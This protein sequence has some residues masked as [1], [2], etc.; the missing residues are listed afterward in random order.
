M[1][2]ATTDD[3]GN[4]VQPSIMSKIGHGALRAVE[5]IGRV[6]AQTLETTGNIV[7]PGVMANIP[8]SELQRDVQYQAATRNLDS[9]EK[10]RQLAASTE[11]DRAKASLEQEQA[12]QAGLLGNTMGKTET[13]NLVRDK[14]FGG[15]GGTAKVNPKTQQPWTMGEAISASIEEAKSAGAAPEEQPLSK[16]PELFAGYKSRIDQLLPGASAQQR[17]AYYPTDNMTAK[18]ADKLYDQAREVAQLSGADQQRKF[19]RDRQTREDQEKKQGNNVE[20]TENGHLMYGT[21]DEAEKH[22]AKWIKSKKGADDIRH[23]TALL[24]DMQAKLN[25]VTTNRGALDQDGTQKAIIAKVLST[26]GGGGITIAGQHIPLAPERGGAIDQ[27]IQAGMLQ[28]ASDSTVNYIQSVLSFREAALALPKMITNSGRQSEVA[29]RALWSTTPGLEPNSQY[30]L[31]QSRRFQGNIDRLRK[32]TPTISG[33]E[34]TIDNPLPELQQV[35][36][37]KNSKTGQSAHWDEAK[38][39]YVD[40]VSGQVV[41]K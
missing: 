5:G 29:S 20:W 36:R 16:Q 17:G 25:D 41:K 37:I 21:Q 31:G 34:G 2:Q 1:P 23:D 8:H 4:T 22:G 9:A 40:D 15:Q 30:V 32:T 11:Q 13:D 27:I 6:G 24:N 33:E 35:D 38:K 14:M 39:A 28:G 10:N 18:Q 19:E 7:A 26:T 12:R 3:Q